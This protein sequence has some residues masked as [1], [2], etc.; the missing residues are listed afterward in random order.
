MDYSLTWWLFVLTF[1]ITCRIIKDYCYVILLQIF[2]RR[3]I[4]IL[5]W[6]NIN[7]LNFECLCYV[8]FTNWNNLFFFNTSVL[9]KL[10]KTET[11]SPSENKN[12]SGTVVHTPLIPALGREAVS[13][14]FQWVKGQPG[15]W[16]EFQDSQRYTL[17]PCPKKSVKQNN[18]NK[19]TEKNFKM[20]ALVKMLLLR[21]IVY[22]QL[23]RC[24]RMA[25]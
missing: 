3:Y 2:L 1:D 12:F 14:R 20:S 25:I 9:L 10:I 21:I 17:E 19:H 16:H 15:L 8:L 23:Y 6:F 13:E 7:N 11:V 24:C 18:T 5:S 22:E 4:T